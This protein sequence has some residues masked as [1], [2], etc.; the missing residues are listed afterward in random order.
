MK[1]NQFGFYHAPGGQEVSV[2]LTLDFASNETF[3]PQDG[4]ALI[5]LIANNLSMSRGGAVASPSSLAPAVVLSATTSRRSRTA[6]SAEAASPASTES[7][8][9]TTENPT[10]R[11]R[12]RGSAAPAETAETKT[13]PSEAASS[14]SDAPAI[15][16]RRRVAAEPTE[17]T[18]A[19]AELLKAASEAASVLGPDNVTVALKEFGVDQVQELKGYDLRKE[20]LDY[21]GTWVA[22]AKAA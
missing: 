11:G 1:I 8:P 18:I 3:E 14:P 19:D 2:Q 9:E 13:A 12:R 16:R 15:G 5:D 7:K 10:P 22:E 6:S 20:F 21:L 4:Q 17:P